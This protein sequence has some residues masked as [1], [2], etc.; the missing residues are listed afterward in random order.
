MSSPLSSFFWVM[1]LG[2]TT[3][4]VDKCDT[5]LSIIIGIIDDSRCIDR[6][7]DKEGISYARPAGGQ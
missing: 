4:F 7:A 2:H 5:T 1:R 6:M 3:R